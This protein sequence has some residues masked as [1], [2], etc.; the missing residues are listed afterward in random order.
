M[1]DVYLKPTPR[2]EVLQKR[3]FPAK[4]RLKVAAYVRV[5][6]E[7]D[8]AIDSL[9]NQA[10]TY[11]EKIDAN[12]EWD[13][14]GI[15][16]DRGISGTKEMRPEFQRMLADC[17]AGK[18]DMIL[19]KSFTRFA[20]NTVVLLETLRELK[21][22]Q[23][24][25]CFE[26][27]NIHSLSENGELLI[28]LLAA[29]AQAESFSASENQRWRIKKKFEEGK[30][31]GGVQMLG[32]QIKNGKF[33]VIP[34]EAEVIRQIFKDYLSGMG[35]N[36]IAKRLNRSRTYTFYQIPWH[37]KSV[38]R[39]LMNEKYAGD[40][41]L[42]KTY[43]LDH[44][45]KKKMENNG[46]KTRYL[47]END[48][49]AIISR[50]MFRDVKV[51]MMERSK[52]YGTKM[53]GKNSG[54]KQQLLRYPFSGIIGCSKCGGHYRRK[55]NNAGTK[56]AKPVWICNTF[57]T[58]GKNACN[59]QQIPEDILIAK[60][61][62]VLGIDTLSDVNISAV[63]ELVQVPENGCLI[64]KLRDGSEREIRWKNRSRRDSWTPEMRQKAR[65]QTL[66]RY[67]T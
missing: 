25:V 37:C 24:N 47:V 66:N 3:I 42:Q 60:T 10:E 15:Y 26:K 64:Y 39:I 50:E 48:H 44:L 23:I 29:Y 13:F 19:T 12:L 7:K 9:E 43:T 51:E 21:R 14:A 56:Y 38:R 65:E 67:R 8:A 20:R 52:K 34:E 45:G 22:L 40:L 62:E 5:S 41:L 57:N 63:L 53:L 61:K 1:E 28:T 18:I 31:A 33:A 46:E 54:A 49:E 59:S 27:D 35:V 11:K 36:A 32:Y 17:R 30:L 55:I 16:E 2:I 58:W 6:T 4:E